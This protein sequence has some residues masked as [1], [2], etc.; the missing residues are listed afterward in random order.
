MTS[1]QLWTHDHI[2]R[3]TCCGS[4]EV[5]SDAELKMRAADALPPLTHCQHLDPYLAQQG[6]AS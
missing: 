5:I 3:C 6:V 1:R 4:W 2:A